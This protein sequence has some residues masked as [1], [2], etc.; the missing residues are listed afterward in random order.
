MLAQGGFASGLAAMDAHRAG[1]SFADWK[2][3]F[4]ERGA[5]P[6]GPVARVPTTIELMK[7]GRS[8]GAHAGP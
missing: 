4:S 5:E 6:T 7:L 8:K 1:G 3:A 2:R